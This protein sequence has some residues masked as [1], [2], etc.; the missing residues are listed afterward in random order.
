ML[1]T[2]SCRLW[3]LTG[4]P[5]PHAIICIHWMG[6]DP[7]VYVD[8]NLKKSVYIRVYEQ[9]MQPLTGKRMLEKVQSKPMSP[10]TIS[11]KADRPKK[12]RKRDKSELE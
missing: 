4:I 2:C 8:D 11:K 12:K 6:K 5:C 10:P 7:D 3:D 1:K 9:L